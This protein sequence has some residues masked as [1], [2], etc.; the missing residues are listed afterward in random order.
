MTA[1]SYFKRITALLLSLITVIGLC[2][3]NY[4][5]GANKIIS[6]DTENEPKNID[7]QLASSQSELTIARNT[8]TG[9]FRINEKGNAEKSL[10]E[11]YKVSSDGLTYEFKIK[12]AKWSNGDDITAD[13]FVF[14]ITRALTPETKSPFAYTLFFIKNAEQ[15]NNGDVGENELGISLI[16]TKSFKLVLNK[17]I[18]DIEY[19]LADMPSMPCN[20]DFF[21][22]CK[23]KYGLSKKDMLHCGPF[24]VSNWT[25]KY[26]KMSRNSE[27]VGEK[28]KPSTLTMTFNE[29]ANKK[30][31]AIK[32]NVIDIAIIESEK[33]TAA[34]EAGLTTHS[35]HNTVWAIIINPNT[36]ITENPLTLSAMTKS[37]DRHSIEDALPAGYSMF[38]GLI[39]P[40]LNLC[41]NKY[42]HYI[43]EYSQSSLQAKEAKNEYMQAIKET[44]SSLNGSTLLY[45]NSNQAGNMAIKIAASWQ[46]N[47]DAYI[48]TEGVTFGEMKKRIKSG[49]YTVALYPIGYEI[50]DAETA[51][52]Q[53]ISYDKNNIFGI[54]NEYF[55]SIMEKA[56]SEADANKK[57][58]LLHQA[59]NFLIE[60]NYVYPVYISPMTIAT[61]PN[62]NG[63]IFDLYRGNFDFSNTVK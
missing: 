22:K 1:V 5:P 46:S 42:S 3:C 35:I 63:Y 52:Q 4:N 9:L 21:N 60:S 26:I 7:P 28:A 24:Y 18:N 50:S 55:D 47:L 34:K 2:S 33:E 31:D 13:D 17:K 20:R 27:Y 8:M 49:N 32:K 44:G 54:Q 23:G 40:E 6:M 37:I 58:K 43:N 48:N 45:V 14:G 16:D 15:F 29:T 53:F 10:C 57:A 59:E 61:T 19:R 12:E 56:Q 11:E 39:A 41:G 38:S 30:I 36:K 62:L 25:D 51:L